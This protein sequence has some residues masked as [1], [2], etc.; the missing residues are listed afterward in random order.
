MY[1]FRLAILECWILQLCLCS[2]AA[3]ENG[4]VE[5]VLRWWICSIGLLACADTEPGDETHAPSLGGRIMFICRILCKTCGEL[6]TRPV[7]VK[8][9][10]RTS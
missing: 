9:V 7:E 3:E 5:I 10:N 8:A 4:W 2:G 6:V 1:R